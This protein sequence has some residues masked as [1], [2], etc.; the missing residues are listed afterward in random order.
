MPSSIKN[1]QTHSI[2][3]PY[4]FAKVVVTGIVLVGLY[5]LF[6][7][8]Q[9][10]SG[11]LELQNKVKPDSLTK[12][13]ERFI[14]ILMDDAQPQDKSVI[15]KLIDK[16]S[17]CPSAKQLWEKI[18][19]KEPIDLYLASPKIVPSRGSWSPETRIMAIDRTLQPVDHKLQSL[20]FELCNANNTFTALIESTRLGEVSQNEHLKKIIFHE[21]ESVK[22][23]HKI[24]VACQ[25]SSNWDPRIDERYGP[26]LEGKNALW[27]TAEAAYQNILSDTSQKNYIKANIQN[28]N[29]VGKVPYCN[30]NPQAPECA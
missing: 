27:R 3:N 6:S 23:H 5:S 10:S 13:K 7:D 4:T 8:Q 24:S 28:W 2:F 21:Y 1:S 29:N 15:K 11:H 20:L 22:C 19:E 12:D 14:R 17:Q 30:K 18:H 16:I 9:A 26:R 25:K